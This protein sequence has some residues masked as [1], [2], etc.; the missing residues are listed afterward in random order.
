MPCH[1]TAWGTTSTH[2]T[3]TNRTTTI[4]L[5]DMRVLYTH[6]PMLYYRQ[7]GPTRDIE[8]SLVTYNC[9]YRDTIYPLT[10]EKQ[11]PEHEQHSEQSKLAVRV[12]CQS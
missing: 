10:S 3:I 1:S 11:D 12:R 9:L 7:T 2:L 5:L 8:S 4:S 6:A